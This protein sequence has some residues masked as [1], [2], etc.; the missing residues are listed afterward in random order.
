MHQSIDIA[1]DTQNAHVGL[2]QHHHPPPSSLATSS[3]P[4]ALAAVP[5]IHPSAGLKR[6]IVVVVVSWL[7][8]REEVLCPS[9]PVSSAGTGSSDNDSL[10]LLLL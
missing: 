2:Q 8:C 1:A 4:F 7:F 3:M 10:L 5:G 9:L 6:G